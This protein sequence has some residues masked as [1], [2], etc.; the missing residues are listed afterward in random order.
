MS[1]PLASCASAVDQARIVF[2]WNGKS[3]GVFDNTKIDRKPLLESFAPADA[4]HFVESVRARKRA[5]GK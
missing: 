1:K 5:T 3:P 2:D 4:E